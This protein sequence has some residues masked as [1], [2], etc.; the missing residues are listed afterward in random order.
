MIEAIRTTSRMLDMRDTARRIYG[1]RYAGLV[2]D[3]NPVIRGAMAR[4]KTGSPLEAALTITS[5]HSSRLNDADVL[6]LLS[7]AVEMCETGA[8]AK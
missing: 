2:A 8:F 6:I 5:N 3:M 1:S 7:A 4:F